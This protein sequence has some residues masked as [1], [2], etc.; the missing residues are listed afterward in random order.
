MSDEALSTDPVAAILAAKGTPL[1]AIGF[2]LAIAG[3]VLP[4][5]SSSGFGFA[6]TTNLLQV[7]GLA[8]GFPVIIVLA[9]LAPGIAPLRPYARLVDLVAVIAGLGLLIQAAFVFFDAQ[10]QIDQTIGNLMPNSVTLTP[11][12]GFAFVM[13]AV[14]ATGFQAIRKR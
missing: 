1:R 5:F 10:R 7:N 13:L 6:E 11:A 14:A 3:I 2:L 8:A 9:L 4:A 12:Y